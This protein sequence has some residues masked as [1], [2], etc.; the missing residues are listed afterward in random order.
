MIKKD[1]IAIRYN[2]DENIPTNLAMRCQIRQIFDCILK[3]VRCNIISVKVAPRNGI[4]QILSSNWKKQMNSGWAVL[5]KI[6]KSKIEQEVST[7]LC[8]HRQSSRLNGLNLITV[9]FCYALAQQHAPLVAIS[10][11]HK[12]NEKFC[13]HLQI[14]I[15]PET[16]FTFRQ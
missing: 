15:P 1:L 5:A 9:L 11:S 2:L 6:S 7:L 16:I 14:P 8:H 3:V 10:S 13:K 4:H 12:D